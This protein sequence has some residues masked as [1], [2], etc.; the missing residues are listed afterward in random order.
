MLMLLMLALDADVVDVDACNTHDKRTL[1]TRLS[2]NIKN[3]R[4]TKGASS[5]NHMK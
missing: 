3:I 1:Q 4:G 2:I 5:T